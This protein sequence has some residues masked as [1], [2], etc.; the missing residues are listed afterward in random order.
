VTRSF[1]L[2]VAVGILAFS[3]PASADVALADWCVNNNGSVGPG[4][5]QP[6]NSCNGGLLAPDPKVNTGSFDTTLEPATNAVST[7]PQTITISFGTGPQNIG[8]FMNYDIDY[9]TYGS[10]GDYGTVVGTFPGP[11]TYELDNEFTSSIFSDFAAGALT[12][13]N[14]VSFAACSPNFP[15]NYCD[16]SWAMDWV[17]NIN[18]AKF[19]GGT[20]TYTASSTVPTKSFYLE[21]T[22]GLSC[23]PSG[24]GPG[25]ESVFLSAAVS[26]TPKTS[27][28]TP[29]PATWPVLAAAGGILFV[30]RKRLARS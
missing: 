21:Q 18:P 29:E 19:T 6:S 15:P 27:T 14:N 30:I 4:T 11:F 25:C 20:I 3:M 16:V 9:L 28:I 12:N 13:A 2:M 26:L 17:A 8:V 5:N 10:N 1:L 22:S 7:S 24:T 23:Q